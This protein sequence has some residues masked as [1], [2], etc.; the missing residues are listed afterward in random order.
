[1]PIPKQ[2]TK[3]VSELKVD[4]KDQVARDLESLKGK[5]FQLVTN[6]ESAL[7]AENPV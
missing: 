3:R 7:E 5:Y 6:A 2:R 4:R 1:M